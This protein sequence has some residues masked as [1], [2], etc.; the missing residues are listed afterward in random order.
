MAFG[1][2][3]E[4]QMLRCSDMV[5]AAGSKILAALL[6]MRH[7]SIAELHISRRHLGYRICQRIYL[8]ETAAVLNINAAAVSFC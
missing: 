4:K 3:R 8:N 7:N 5:Q 2:S 1:H 6:S